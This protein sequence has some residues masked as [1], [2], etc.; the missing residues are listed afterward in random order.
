MRTGF[1]LA[2][3]VVGLVISASRRRAG[4]Q[5]AGRRARSSSGGGGEPD[6]ALMTALAEGLKQNPQWSVEQGD[7]LSALAKFQPELARSARGEPAARPR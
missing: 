4:G 3:L 5:P 2:F 1:G 6:T 7:G